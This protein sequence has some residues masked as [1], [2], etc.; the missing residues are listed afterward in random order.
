MASTQMARAQ[1]ARYRELAHL[2]MANVAQPWFGKLTGER[3]HTG[4]RPTDRLS[5][6][7]P[8]LHCIRLL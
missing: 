5:H 6:W 7:E 8:G 4:A 1:V 3:Q 2:A